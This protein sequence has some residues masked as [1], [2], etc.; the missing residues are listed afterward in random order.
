MSSIRTLSYSLEEDIHLC[1]VYLDISQNP[2]IGINQSKDQFWARVEAEY[3]LPEMFMTQRRPRR[4]LQSRM[5]TILAA[6][7]KFRGCI[8]QIENKNPSGASEQDIINQAKMLLSQ[9]PKYKK[10]FKY[11]H[12]WPILKDC[13]K[14]T[15]NNANGATRFQQQGETLLYPNQALSVLSHQHR[16]PLV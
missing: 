12:V 9:D 16:H 1:R 8:N 14:F 2:I 10:G 7:S 15:N 11:D 4:S 5:T 3:H 13:E 6:V